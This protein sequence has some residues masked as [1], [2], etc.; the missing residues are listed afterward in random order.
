MIEIERGWIIKE[1]EEPQ[2]RRISVGVLSN[3]LFDR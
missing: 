2:G 3:M 1:G